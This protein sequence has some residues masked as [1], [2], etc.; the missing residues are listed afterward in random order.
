M[1]IFFFGLFGL[2][3]GAGTILAQTSADVGIRRAHLERELQT[4]EG[5]IEIQKTILQNK[6]RDSVSLERD[7]SILNANIQSAQ[8]SIKVRDLAIGKLT[9]DIRGKESTIA[10]LS[11]KMERE[12]TSLAQLLRKERELDSYSLVEVILAKE[13]I[14][15]FFADIESFDSIKAALKE[16]FVA[17]EETRDATAKQKEA[18]TGK[19]RDEEELRRIQNLQK[20]RIE[21]NKAEKRKILDV[22]RG[23]ESV[24]KKVI[25]NKE[26]NAAVIRAELFNLRGS[27]AIP[28]EKALNLANLAAAKTGVRPALI[29]GVIAEESNL[30]ENVGTGHWQTDMCCPPASGKKDR[31]RPIFLE[32]TKKLG[33]NPDSMPVSRK[34]GYGWGGA[35][36]PAQFI[37]STWVLYEARLVNA[38]GHNPPN[39]WEPIDAFMASAMLLKDNGAAKQTATAEWKAAMCYLAGCRST[40]PKSL[41]F[42]GDDVIALASKYQK[43][44]DVLAGN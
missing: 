26:K 9:D 30:G 13:D 28:F 4:L 37:P 42:Y 35:M 32:I 29:L 25:Q 43:M 19:Q 22:S 23:Q 6:Q 31:D 44:I 36:G 39:P 5:E 20:K 16:S 34:P 33:L 11:A 12:K 40:Y 10:A 24:Y 3:F 17:I 15:E 1:V 7:I 2:L 14:S 41:H 21:E 27:A 18:L 38:T 8:L